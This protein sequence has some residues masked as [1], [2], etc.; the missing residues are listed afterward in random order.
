MMGG[1]TLVLA[2][3]ARQ[4][5]GMISA[6]ARHLAFLI[7]AL[8]AFV[9]LMAAQVHGAGRAGPMP[10]PVQLSDAR[11]LPQSCAQNPCKDKRALCETLCAGLGHTILPEPAGVIRSAPSVARA[12]LAPGPVRDGIVPALD[13]RPPILLAV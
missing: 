10:V 8:L 12:R 7:T 5:A 6:R 9:M 3:G 1:L 2:K 4:Y 11:H 13:P